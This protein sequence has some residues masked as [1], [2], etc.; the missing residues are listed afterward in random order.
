MIEVIVKTNEGECSIKRPVENDYDITWP[1]IG[2]AFSDALKGLGY[3]PNDLDDFLED[4]VDEYK[5]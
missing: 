3:V 4:K 5:M 2:V 1:E